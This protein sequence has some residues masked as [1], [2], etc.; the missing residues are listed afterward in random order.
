MPDLSYSLYSRLYP[1]GIDYPSK[2][3]SRI[4]D[5]NEVSLLF[6]KKSKQSSEEKQ[7]TVVGEES[8]GEKQTLIFPSSAIFVQSIKEATNNSSDLIIKSI[9]PNLTLI[10]IDNSSGCPD[11]K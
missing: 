8:A 2:A 4:K 3:Y 11:I 5:T 9:P 10:Y 7:A 1:K 6:N